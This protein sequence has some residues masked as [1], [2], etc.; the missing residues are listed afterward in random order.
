MT[1]RLQEALVY[2]AHGLH[3]IPFY[4]HSKT[5]A[6]AAGEIQ[7]YRHRVPSTEEL[8]RWFRGVDCNIGLITGVNGF[9]ILDVDGDLGRQ[10]LKRLPA[11]PRTPTLI[12]GDGAQ[13]YFQ[14]NEVLPSKIGLL[15]GIDWLSSDRQALTASS[16]HPDG[17]VYH[18]ADGLSLGEVECARVPSWIGTL[19]DLDESSDIESQGCDR[20]GAGP[21]ARSS[22]PTAAHTPTPRHSQKKKKSRDYTS[23]AR[24][25]L[26]TY[27]T[28]KSLNPHAIRQL[29]GD[30]EA[31]A[32]AARFLGLGHAPASFLCWYHPDHRPS[33]SL[34]VDQRTGAWKVHDWHDDVH[35]ALADLFAA[36]II[37]HPMRLTGTPTLATWWKRLLLACKYLAA[38]DVPRKPLPP[39][40]RQSVVQVYEGFLLNVQCHWLTQPGCAVP[41]T[42]GFAMSW[43]GM[44]SKHL[45]DYALYRLR[46][47]GQM[48]PAGRQNRL[49]IFLPGEGA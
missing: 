35:Y 11:L 10:M 41:F 44:K 48:R 31:N 32:V 43:C 40:A 42:H 16:I 34:Y 45:V 1:N 21:Q 24:V 2:K 22:C 23:G 8:K 27:P 25:I 36:E 5:P 29:F 15:P 3:P 13:Y 28:I 49:Q 38:P 33:M 4:P 30:Q 7:P 19:L 6:F 12:T 14:G 39:D 46:R 47:D 17:P 37:G 26:E 9:H 20:P 18:F